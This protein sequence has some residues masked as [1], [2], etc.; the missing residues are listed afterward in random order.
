[1]HVRSR[2]SGP[3]KKL[4]QAA[5]TFPA[6]GKL[7]AGAGIELANVPLNKRYEHD[8]EAMLGRTRSST[9]LV[10]TSPEGILV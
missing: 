5:P 10:Y 2:V 4:V 7:A 1:M 9:G 8:L 6:L 3:G